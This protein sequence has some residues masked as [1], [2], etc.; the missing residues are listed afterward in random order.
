MTEVN[1]GELAAYIKKSNAIVSRL[2]NDGVLNECYTSNGKKIYLEKAIKAIIMN[3]GTDYLD[4]VD[5]SEY[6]DN[7]ED[8][9]LFTAKNIDEL[10]RLL[11]DEPSPSKKIDMMDKFWSY[12]IRQQKFLQ[13]EGDLI[14]VEMAKGAVEKLLSPLNQYLN[15]Q[16][17]SLRNHYPDASDEIVEWLRE[18]NN[19]QK[20]QLRDHD[21]EA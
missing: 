3:K 16:A 6:L 10:Q 18:E 21:W 17:N 11:D 14:T 7:E 9:E 4:G 12:K 20:E 5:L 8:K 13:T 15:D 2:A 19:R 1:K